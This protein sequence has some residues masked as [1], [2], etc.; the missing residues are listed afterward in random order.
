MMYVLSGRTVSA[1]T[2]ESILCLF[3]Q[4]NNTLV[5][6]ETVRHSSTY[7]I[8]YVSHIDAPDYVVLGFIHVIW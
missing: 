5:S 3:K 4:K 2:R 1:L 8:L 6:T 7:I